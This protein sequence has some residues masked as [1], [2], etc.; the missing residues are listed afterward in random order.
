MISAGTGTY[1]HMHVLTHRDTYTN[2]IVGFVYL[3]DG[4]SVFRSLFLESPS[5][6]FFFKVIYYIIA[7]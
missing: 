1:N 2:I 6:T 3:M 7:L 4:K 5:C